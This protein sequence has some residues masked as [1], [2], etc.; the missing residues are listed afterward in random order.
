MNTLLIEILACLFAAAILSLI[1]GWLARG[2]RAKK[3]LA[4]ANKAWKAKHSELE[5]RY[6][7]D[8]EHLEEQVRLLDTEKK[9][10]STKHDSISELLSENE[11]SVHKARADAIELN[12]QQADTQERLQRIIAQKDEELKLFRADEVK[13]GRNITGALGAVTMS[14]ED[15][16]AKIA[17]LSAKREAWESERQRLINAMSDG[18]GDDQDTIAIDPADLPTEPMDQTVRIDSFD[19]ESDNTV[20]LDDDQTMLL[21]DNHMNPNR[22]TNRDYS[23]PTLGG[24]PEGNDN[25]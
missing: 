23:K 15:T 21:D 24:K 20:A 8:T 17:T 11:I 18:D 2:S 6:Q 7:T 22:A 10:I 4:N 9:Q 3:E 16:E 5:F 19:N 25:S 13:S 12:R 14:S 1:I